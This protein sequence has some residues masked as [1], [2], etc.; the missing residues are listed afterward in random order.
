MLCLSGFELYSRW[1]PLVTKRRLLPPP[2][3]NSEEAAL[4]ARRV[5]RKV[6]TDEI[7]SQYV[8]KNL[9]LLEQGPHGI[10]R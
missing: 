1:V 4:V 6:L 3:W 2:E 9:D 8:R 7:Y 10:V 5:V